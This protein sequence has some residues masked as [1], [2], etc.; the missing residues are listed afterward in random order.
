[1]ARAS[2]TEENQA[3]VTTNWAFVSLHTADPGT[4]G[5]SEVAG[6]SYARVAVTWNAPS[7]GSVSNSSSLSINLPASTTAGF[8]GIWSAITSGTYMIG[9]ILSPSITTGGSAGVVSI[10]SSALIASAS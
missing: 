8:F 4:T 3:L 2:T 9:G 5:A 1:M 6:G 10:A 7:G